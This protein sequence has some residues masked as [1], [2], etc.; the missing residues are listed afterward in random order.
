[1]NESVEQALLLIEQ[2]QDYAIE[3][4]KGQKRKY[5]N[6]DYVV[7]P[8]AVAE[9][10]YNAMNETTE[11]SFSMWE[12]AIMYAS[13]VLHDTVEDTSST[14][15]EIRKLFGDQVESNVYWLTNVSKFSDG[16]RNAR[17]LIDLNHILSAPL[18]AICI[19]IA[20]VICNCEDIV[21][22]DFKYSDGSFSKLYIKE[23]IEFSLALEQ[24]VKEPDLTYSSNSFQN[25]MY[26]VYL[27]LFNEM[28][29][30]LER[31]SNLIKLIHN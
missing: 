31:Q 21:E 30:V 8:F 5:T 16:K 3:Q 13:A 7:H 6:E 2:T 12:K 19:K 24:Y 25:N 18:P 20:D 27:R 11:Y 4:H 9:K 10:I 14:F 22:N 17:K 28:N 26:F 1:M 29:E 15:D 23:K